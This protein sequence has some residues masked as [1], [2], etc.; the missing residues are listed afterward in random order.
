[1][2][3]DSVST[4]RVS[5]PGNSRLLQLQTQLAAPAQSYKAD[6]SSYWGGRRNGWSPHALIFATRAEVDRSGRDEYF[7][8]EKETGTIRVLRDDVL[9]KIEVW[10]KGRAPWGYHYVKIVR[11]MQYCGE[12]EPPQGSGMCTLSDEECDK[13]HASDS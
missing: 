5:G 12:G 11:N 2:P 7:L 4:D 6:F 3:R 10:W 8:C 13:Q 9:L 1:M